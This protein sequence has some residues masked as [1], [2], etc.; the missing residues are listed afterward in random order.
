[1]N[2]PGV[3]VFVL[4]AALAYSHHCLGQSDLSREEAERR[5]AELQQEITTLKAE[6]VEARSE[7]QREQ[8]E[9]REL[10]LEIDGSSRQA[11]ALE[12]QQATHRQELERLEAQKGEQLA[13]LSARKEQLA[14]VLRSAYKVDRHSRIKL[15]LNQDDPARLNRMLAYYEYFNRQHIENIALLKASLEMLEQTQRGIEQKL[16]DLAS[17]A[18]QLAETLQRLGGQRQ[19]R[20]G[21]MAELDHQ[22]GSE[23]ARL[24]E[25]E[26][27]RSDLVRLLERLED[28][29]ADIPADLGSHLSVAQQKGRL[30]MPTAGRVQHAFGQRRGGSLHWQGWLIGADP[31]SEVRSVAY[32]RVAF[33]DW[34][35][36]YGLILIL[37]HGGGFL[38][39]YGNN[40]S[41]LVE[42]GDWVEPGG[43]I[44]V[45]GSNPGMSQGLYFELRKD[46][47][48]VDPAA[49]IDR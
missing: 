22:I 14:E 30:P 20:V 25:L 43:L 39:L 6:L 11:R 12:Q 36:G 41:L 32:G 2:K 26:R 1:M 45:V 47:K 8:G 4:A 19:D 13:Q 38:S 15:V 42:V 33:A 44:A 34:L 3:T 5:L 28:A 29:L 16:A 31:G 7:Y 18:E 27:N 17:T 46:G 23:E 49:W 9:L 21:L 40:E 37:D 48:A 10:D 24:A 35:R